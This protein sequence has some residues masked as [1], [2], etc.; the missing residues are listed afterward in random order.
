MYELAEGPRRLTRHY[1]VIENAV[2]EPQGY[3]DDVFRSRR[4]ALMAAKERAEWLAAVAGLSVESLV[5]TGRYFITTGRPDDAGRLIA[6]EHCD[7]SECLAASY[8]SMLER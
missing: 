5:G 2:G 3:R 4:G 6:V 8:G 1:H 7:E